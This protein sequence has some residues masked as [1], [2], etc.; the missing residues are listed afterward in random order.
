MSLKSRLFLWFLILGLLPLL[1]MGALSVRMGWSS[2]EREARTRLESTRDDKLRALDDQVRV[3]TREAAIYSRV[4]EIYNALGMLRAYD[5][6]QSE[7]YLSDR[8]YVSGAFAPFVQTLGYEDAL[9]CDDYGTVLYSFAE[10]PLV[11]RSL[12]DGPAAQTAL[13]SAWEIAKSGE[14]A[15]ADVE[16]SP[17]W[18]GA[19]AAF[20]AAPIRS[21]AGDVQGVAVLRLPLARVSGLLALGAGKDG[22]TY[23]VGP[24]LRMRSDAPLD[25]ERSLAASLAGDVRTH[26]ADTQAARLA[27]S[28][29]SGMVSG[30]DF[31]GHA[32]LTA[33]AP[34]RFGGATW[35]LLVDAPVKALFA[36]VRRLLWFALCGAGLLT[37]LVLL[38]TNRITTGLMRGLGAG[39]RRLTSAAEAVA[40][41]DLEGVGAR[42]TDDGV[43]G[44]M[45]RMAANLR[46]KA[47]LA[48]SIADGDLSG[49]IELASERDALGR[50]LMTMSANLNRVLGGAR[51][52][53][54]RFNEGASQV[55]AA[56]WAVSQGASEQA[57]SLEEIT[58]SLA[59]VAG[60]AS[61]NAAGAAESSALALEIGAEVRLGLETLDSLESGMND[62]AE[63]GRSVARL[64]GTIDDLA[65]QIN[66][67]SLNAAVEAARAGRHGK[68]FAVV[69]EEVRRLAG[70]SAKAAEEA[71]RIIDR[72]QAATR[73]GHKAAGK[74]AGSLRGMASRVERMGELNRRVA[75]AGGR[76]AGELSRIDQGLARIRAVT[77]ENTATAEQS[78]A[79]SRELS[80][81]AATLNRLLAMFRLARAGRGR[82]GAESATEREKGQ[83]VASVR[84][85][86]PLS[87]QLPPQ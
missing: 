21:H 57:S 45:G 4:K 3:W 72:S 5:D 8:E 38:A 58:A 63:A 51:Q 83:G 84:R 48:A 80:A 25:K 42:A 2:L 53:A 40:A 29:K 52:A 61:E 10:S 28:G 26:G 34:V 30:E 39:P 17:L 65:F 32:V 56:S 82:R 71:A 68:G 43:Y 70:S 37:V 1:A 87:R 6:F 20:V 9:M 14:T 22:Q 76:Q 66:L 64:A 47:L 33:Y 27:L 75:E 78:A 86:L 81:Q 11:G 74:T 23:L 24:D 15:F 35:A 54:R 49:E 79:A 31:N 77:Q 41:G 44:A 67:L 46:A 62:I 18:G 19:P 36:P 12:L 59:E 60:R 55:A 13:A 16:A 73:Q 85:A 7:D 69:A 50:A